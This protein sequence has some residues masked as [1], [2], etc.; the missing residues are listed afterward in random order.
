MS[1][2]AARQGVVSETR[3]ITCIVRLA[4]GQLDTFHKLLMARSFVLKDDILYTTALCNELLERIDV[5]AKQNLQVRQWPLPQRP[6][7]TTCVRQN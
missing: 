5:L 7:I 1:V 2:A 4:S 6:T 3:D